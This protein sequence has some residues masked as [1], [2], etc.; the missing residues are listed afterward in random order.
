MWTSYVINLAPNVERMRNSARQLEAQGLPWRRID[1]VNGWELSEDEIARVYD[2][3]ANARRGKYP[4]VPAEIGCYL[5]H[6]EAWRAIAASDQPG[7]FIFEDDFAAN[8]TLGPVLRALVEDEP[9]DWDMVKLFPS[10][11]IHASMPAARWGGISASWC[12]TRCPP[13]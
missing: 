2:A 13:A 10:T 6:I 4:L 7:G 9:R 11:P 12:P 8:G 3:R 5:S 1:A